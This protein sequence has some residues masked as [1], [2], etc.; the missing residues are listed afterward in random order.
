[1]VAALQDQP[2]RNAAL[3]VATR[4]F[5]AR[6]FD[7]TPL[8]AIA[9]ELGASKQAILHHFGTKERLRDAVFE[10]M[11]AHWQAA[12]PRL[13]AA[14]A[15]EDRFDAVL[16]ELRRFFTDD[17][18]RARLVVREMLDRPN[19]IGRLLRGPVRS[20]IATIAAYIRDGQAAGRHFDDVDPEAYLVHCLYFVIASAAAAPLI[21]GAVEPGAVGR[22]RLDGE[23]GR[24][25]KAALFVPRSTKRTRKR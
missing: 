4:L 20:W 14:S 3:A 13:L 25:A 1:M 2:L 15:S 11:L 24:F 22:E 21:H 23:L 10:A 5:A 18:D 17:P 19:E 16:G 12:L 6:G 9:D 7:A 8:Q